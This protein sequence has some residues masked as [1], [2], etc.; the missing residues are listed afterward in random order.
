MTKPIRFGLNHMV[1]PRLTPE[2]L[3]E[4]AAELGATAVELR[5]DIGVNA[6]SDER[7]A[8]A[9][10]ARAGDLGVEIIAINALQAFNVWNDDLARRAEALARVAA[11]CGA[12]GLVMCPLH[13]GR[14]PEDTAARA[15]QL[16]RGLAGIRPILGEYGLL[17]FVEPLGMATSSLRSKAAAL[18]AIDDIGGADVYRLNHDTFHHRV[19]GE[20]RL[21]AAR[22]GIVHISG[23][24]EP[25]LDLARI[26]ED[27]RVLVGTRDR[28]GNV[29]QLMALRAGG[30]DGVVSFEPISSAFHAVADPLPLLADSI[31][32]VRAALGA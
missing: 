9:V 23:V 2:R 31:A 10:G 24:D 14:M 28:I 18:D 13:D 4:A 7:R 11:A 15:E 27:Y 1:A 6:V 16:R 8:R 19:A 21:F 30:Y 12:V 25:S 5:N 17:G 26:S 3:I 20:D 29:S 22:T 32:H